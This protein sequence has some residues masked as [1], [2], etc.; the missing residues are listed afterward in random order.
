MT[1][2]QQPTATT[3]KYIPL[4]TDHIGT[5]AAHWQALSSNAEQDVPQWLHDTIDHAAMPRGLVP[6][7][8][9][10]PT[11]H[12]LLQADHPHIQLH[13]IIAV[14]GERPIKL[15]AAFPYIYSPY[16]QHV[17]IAQI[18]ACEATL[19]AVLQVETEDGTK[20][21]AFDTLYAVNAGQY[22][23]SQFYRASFSGLAYQLEKVGTDETLQVDDP[24][25]IRHH[26]AL[27]QIL[28]KNNGIAPTDLQAKID[29]WQPQNT[30]DEAPVTLS[31]SKMAAYLFG[32]EF[33]QED[34]AWVQGE[35]LGLQQTRLFGHTVYLYDVAILKEADALPLV[36]RI[37]CAAA[38]LGSTVLQVGDY[39]RGNIWLQISIHQAQA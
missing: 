35:I 39:V 23:A 22:Q 33:G 30:D 34:E 38:G 20:I 26:R 6:A 25:A 12:W 13:Q 3:P 7:D 16:W 29:A 15:C 19:E 1:V 21:H 32:E 24:A 18:A 27:N 10:L 5:H 31:L 17:K 2:Q 4:S 14:D 11:T 37:A 36:V 28:A 8:Q 9:P